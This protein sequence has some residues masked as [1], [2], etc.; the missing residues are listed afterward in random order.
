LYFR[1]GGHSRA[2]LEK[3][4]PGRVLGIEWDEEAIRK[5]KMETALRNDWSLI[6]AILP[7]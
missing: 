5:F 3:N 2:I 7:K 1:F 6:R 4:A